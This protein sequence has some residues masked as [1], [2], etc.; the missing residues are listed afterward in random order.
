LSPTSLI[1]ITHIIAVA[2]TIALV[3]V[4][5]LPPLMPLLLPPKSSLSSLHSTL[6]ANAIARFIPLT[7]FITRHPYPHRH[8]L[9][10]LTLFVTCSH[11]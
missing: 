7:L 4:N 1:T 8:R 5:H 11:R 2:I 3:V 10:A 9:I 6:I